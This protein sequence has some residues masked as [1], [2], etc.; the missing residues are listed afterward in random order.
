M[1]VLLLLLVGL[2]SSYL[3]AA[4]LVLFLLIIV[5]WDLV[6]VFLCLLIDASSRKGHG[7]TNVAVGCCRCR[8]PHDEIGV[9]TIVGRCGHG[10]VVALRGWNGS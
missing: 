5:S 1:R 7:D 8:S 3:L 4:L 6:G 2:R 9:L 10:M